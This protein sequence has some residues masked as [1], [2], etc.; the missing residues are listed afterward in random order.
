MSKRLTILLS[1]LLPFAVAAQ[2][3]PEMAEQLRS[4]G[5][6]YVVIA[7]IALIFISLS[8]FLVYLERRVSKLEK[9]IPSASNNKSDS[10][11]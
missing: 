10:L 7:V 3:E 1:V 9:E 4:D 8:A 11:H 6:I 5:K 2:K